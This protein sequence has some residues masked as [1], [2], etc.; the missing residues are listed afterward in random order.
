MKGYSKIKIVIAPALVF[1]SII[2]V[3]FAANV[4]ATPSVSKMS[5]GVYGNGIIQESETMALTGVWDNTSLDYIK[6]QYASSATWGWL[7]SNQNLGYPTA[8]K[9]YFYVKNVAGLVDS[10]YNYV[11]VMYKATNPSADTSVKMLLCNGGT[12]AEVTVL[13]DSVTTTSAWTLTDPVEVSDTLMNRFGS[14]TGS[15]SNSIFIP[16]QNTGGEYQIKAIYFFKTQAEA[17]SFSQTGY[18]NSISFGGVQETECSFDVPL[19]ATVDALTYDETGFEVIAKYTENGVPT[20]SDLSSTCTHISGS[21]SGVISPSMKEYIAQD[22]TGSYLMSLTIENIP[23]SIGEI[24]FDVKPYTKTNN[25]KT[26]GQ[27]YSL[28]YMNG[29]LISQ[30][31]IQIE[32]PSTNKWPDPVT[33]DFSSSTTLTANAYMYVHTDN[34]GSAY[35]YATVNEKGA[36][37]MLYTTALPNYTYY[38]MPRFSAANTVSDEYKYVRI[39]YM[40]DA[41]TASQIKLMNNAKGQMITLVDDTSVSGGEWVTSDPVDISGSGILARYISGL[42][43][44]LISN[45]TSDCGLYIKSITFYISEEHAYQYSDNIAL[46]FGPSGNASYYGD[47]T[48]PSSGIWSYDID[49][50]AL[51]V[52][53]SSTAFVSASKYY[54][55]AKFKTPSEYNTSYKY[56][57][58]LYKTD[59][60]STNL[61]A[62]I[63]NNGNGERESVLVAPSS[64]WALSDTIEV[65]ASIVT[66]NAAGLPFTLS[67]NKTTSGCN[68]YVRAIYFFDSWQ[69][70]DSVNYCEL[71]SGMTID[72]VRIDKYKIVIADDAVLRIQNTA[73][74]LQQSIREATGV[75]VDIISDAQTETTNEILIGSTNRAASLACFPFQ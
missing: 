39:T 21:L 46:N 58:F 10:N 7:N 36:L 3:L 75:K 67:F 6:V 19:I 65:P 2:I 48:D 31:T 74:Y 55:I 16:T 45:I 20:T 41:T 62:S 51:H 15:Y 32:T 68:Y 70:A 37:K 4:T 66:R 13:S 1:I 64:E 34:T 40:T 47:G 28:V 56:M 73:K 61:V 25:V 35:E 8:S 52:A 50:N 29:L 60:T 42:H 22:L 5:F 9:Y 53:Y 57:R 44:G 49:E 59:D 30:N 63:W 12:G 11:R 17:N 43:C 18:S 23:I 38:V 24:S 26:Y 71:H 27:S 69:E 54:F 33:M 14:T 72:G